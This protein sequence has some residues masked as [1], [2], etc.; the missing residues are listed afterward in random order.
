MYQIFA[1]DT[2]IYDST[3]EDYKIGKGQITLE[4][5]KSGSFV[6]SLYPDH[7]YFD[8]FVKLKTVITVYKSGRIVFRGRVLNDVTD[9]WNNKVLTCEG[10][11][12]FLQD[13]IIRPYSFTGTPEAYFT[14]IINQHNSQVDDF[15]KFKVGDVTVSTGGNIIRSNTEYETSF[16]NLN[17]RLIDESTG[18]YFYVTHDGND[19]IPTINYISDFTNVATQT[20]EFGQNLKNYTK[21]VKA[22]S[23]KTAIIPLGKATNDTRLTIA[24]VNDGLDYVHDEAGVSL[25][26]WIVG[27]VIFDDITTA[28][29][30]KTEAETYLQGVMTQNVTIELTAIDLHLIDKNIDSFRINDYIRVI[31]RPHNFD[32]TLLCN[33]MT[34]DLLKPENDTLILGYTYSSFTESNSK[35]ASA[36][37]SISVIK[38]SVNNINN[39]VNNLSEEVTVIKESTVDITPTLE[40]MQAEIEAIEAAVSDNAADIAD[41]IARVTELENATVDN[42]TVIVTDEQNVAATLISTYGVLTIGDLTITDTQTNLSDVPKNVNVQYTLNRTI[43]YPRALYANDIYIGTFGTAGDTYSTTIQ[44]SSGDTITIRFVSSI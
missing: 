37:A 10:E 39:T 44:I 20:I 14:S 5:N 27:T 35:F 16:V 40:S 8:R 3:L 4:T 22:E 43:S 23:L 32:A 9:Y 24:S 41:L 12:G 38:S 42:I 7:F 34:I 2:L 19:E 29:T 11:L 28:A 15:K 13:S 6:F 36:T 30:L 25:Y 33:K 31:S 21:T 18:G 1:D 26:G 17:S